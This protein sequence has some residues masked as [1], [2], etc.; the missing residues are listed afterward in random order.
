MR[1]RWWQFLVVLFLLLSIVGGVHYY[2]Y[3]HLVAG[4]GPFS[5][6]TLGLIRA[7]F[8]LGVVSFPVLRLLARN[9]L[10]RPSVLFDWAVVVWLGLVFYSFLLGLSVQVVASVGRM[11]GLLALASPFTGSSPERS[12]AF[13]V[14]G[15][16]TLL[17]TVGFLRGQA[18]PRVVNLEV[19]LAH[20]PPSLDGFSVVQLSDVHVGTFARPS[21]LRRIVE[22][23]NGLAPDLVVITGD[24]ADEEASHLAPVEP[25][26]GSLQSRHGVLAVP[27]NHDF[28]AGIDEVVRR[29]SS[30]GIR[31]L[32]NE[33]VVVADAIDVYGLDDPMGAR[34]GGSRV[35]FEHV[36]GP[37]AHER[38]TILLYHQPLGYPKLAEMGVG[39]VLS[40]HTHGGQLWPLGYLSRLFYP[41]NAGFFRIGRSHFY[42]SR[43]TGTWGPP[44]RFGAPSEIVNIRLRSPAPVLGTASLRRAVAVGE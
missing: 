10:S 1:R 31:F 24:L 14:A 6:T 36:I 44:M 7:L 40:G 39:L 8:A 16:T 22:T 41:Y 43:G 9:H 15:L 23:V 42:V 26:L 27:G 33:K 37:E 13:L 12:A 29:A 34:M 18:T 38:P 19:P 35:P 30:C 25:I 21:R 17:A 3:S 5:S 32:R 28:F 4:F 11:T 20:L 2:L